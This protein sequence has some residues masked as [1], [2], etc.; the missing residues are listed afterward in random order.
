MPYDPAL[1]TPQADVEQRM[2]LVPAEELLAE[3]DA[4]IK[5][6]APLRAR[7]GPGGCWD[8]LRRVHR[9]TIAMKHRA[10]AVAAGQRVTE[11]YLE[12]A[13]QADPDY[14]AFIEAGVKEKIQHTELEN[15][16]QGITD[17][18]MRGQ[19]VARFLTA[20]LGLEPRS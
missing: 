2:Q 8:D 3:R 7:H 18:L 13:A 11:A 10:Q 17:Q 19:A 16:V 14:L 9:A 15:L 1:R 5:K 12:D 4:L 6:I 20:E